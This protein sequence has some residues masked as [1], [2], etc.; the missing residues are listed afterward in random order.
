MFRDYR[1]LLAPGEAATIAVIAADRRQAR[2]VMRFMLGM[3]TTVALLSDLITAQTA[4]S[5]TLRNG[6]VIEIHT[7]SFRVTR[8][9]SLVAAIC[10]EIAF[11]RSDD[12]AANPA[13]EILRALRPGLSN[14][15]R[16]VAAGIIAL[17][18]ARASIS[19]VPPLL[20]P[21]WRQGSGVARHHAGDESRH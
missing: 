4:E 18:Q 6:V 19:G 20:G 16:A 1:P 17:R 11:W 13:D 3:F 12:S 8:G 5:L 15:K 10:D 21:G 14:L 2:S 9:Y 7:A